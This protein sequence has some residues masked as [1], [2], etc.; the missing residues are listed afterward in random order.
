MIMHILKPLDIVVGLKIGLNEK[1]ARLNKM[2]NMVLP[3]G[4]K[5][6]NSIGDLSEIL[7]KAKGD[8]SRS[9]GR[10]I[11][12]GLIA[13]RKAKKGDPQG[14]NRKFYT[15]QRGAMS[16]L[17]CYGIRHVVVP[18]KLGMGRG[19]PSGWNC[20]HI[21]SPMNPPEIPLVW[22]MP[23]GGASGELL[24]PLYAKVPEVVQGEPELYTLL[25]LIDVM[26]TGKPREL[27]YAKEVLREKIKELYS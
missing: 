4:M 24:E 26:R 12:L 9:V 5:H 17:L 20:P 18:E 23:G 14:V 6:S 27:G 11:K 8:V 13:E 15:L 25:S 21:K 16:D 2:E 22:P 7:L 10:L 19:V 3:A 1:T